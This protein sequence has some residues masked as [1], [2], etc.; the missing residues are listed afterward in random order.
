MFDYYIGMEDPVK[1]SDEDLKPI[2]ELGEEIQ[3][4]AEL[5]LV[6]CEKDAML[7]A[8]YNSVINRLKEIEVK[9]FAW[10]VKMVTLQIN[11]RKCIQAHI[12]INS[13]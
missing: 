9:V 8:D 5:A 7:D 10:K 3:D 2:Q 1:I 6:N 13:I 4:M 12:E 11:H